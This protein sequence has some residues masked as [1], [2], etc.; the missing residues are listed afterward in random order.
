MDFLRSRPTRSAAVATVLALGI[1]LSG[2]SAG[3]Q[4]AT[5][6]ASASAST[7][8]SAA[9]EPAQVANLDG[10]K[11]TGAYGKEPTVTFT[12]FTV[13]D[14]Q[15]KV[16]SQGTGRKVTAD[17]TVEV[18]YHG[19]DG[20]TGKVFDSSFASGKPVSFPLNGVIPGFSKG[21]IGKTQGSR[22]LIAIPGKDG[23]DSAGGNPQAG[24]QVGDTLVFVVD[25]V[26]VPL[27]GPEGDKVTQPSGQPVIGGALNDPKVTI[28]SGKAPTSLL[29]QP[30]IK[31]KG[32][33]VT[34]QSTIIVN[35]RGWL[36][37]GGKQIDDTYKSKP[38][39]GQL[40][41]LIPGWAEGL[42]GQTVGSRVLLVIPPSKGYPQGEPD[43]GIPAGATLVY[44]IDILQAS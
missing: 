12:P 24:I 31:G 1:G 6:S 25:I 30:L 41:N 16:L 4:K 37:D 20:R 5:A 38:E 9:P 34:D 2:C 33:T 22:V 39:S 40:S 10:V 35:E 42:K 11:V 26:S 15:S 17:D 18:N 27:T 23:Y 19:V 29:V 3:Q 32:A 8:P 14:T 44:V 21:L 43:A 36:W 13:A 28:P 7:S